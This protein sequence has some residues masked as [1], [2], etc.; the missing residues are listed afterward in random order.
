[1]IQKFQ[2]KIQDLKY[3]TIVVYEYNKRCLVV[4][5]GSGLRNISVYGT[6]FPTGTADLDNSYLRE[7]ALVFT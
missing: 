5:G 2:A 7:A 3:K 6:P 1:M 4:D